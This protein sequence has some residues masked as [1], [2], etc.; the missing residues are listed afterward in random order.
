MRDTAATKAFLRLANM[1]YDDMELEVH[2]QILSQ[3][4]QEMLRQGLT[5]KELAKKAGVGM[6]HLSNIGST[7]STA[8]RLAPELARKLMEALDFRPSQTR[9]V[10]NQL[11][12][13]RSNRVRRRAVYEQEHLSDLQTLCHVDLN[14]KPPAVLVRLRPLRKKEASSDNAIDVLIQCN[15]RGTVS[16]FETAG[17][18]MSRRISGPEAADI[19]LPS[20]TEAVPVFLAKIFFTLQR[21][22]TKALF[23]DL[24]YYDKNEWRVLVRTGE[25]S[26]RRNTLNL[27]DKSIKVF[28]RCFGI[29]EPQ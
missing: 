22:Y 24:R 26:R 5:K 27:L 1:F 6:V 7:S 21:E 10:L 3:I 19:L 17:K 18:G 23:S 25:M 16:Y 29:K 28:E 2:Q 12:Y 14:V 20:R 15:R 4:W 11:E 8:R 9:P 13:L